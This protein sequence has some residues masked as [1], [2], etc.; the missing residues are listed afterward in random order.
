MVEPYTHT[1]TH[2]DIH[3]HGGGSAH[4]VCISSKLT[5]TSMDNNSFCASLCLCESAP[6]YKHAANAVGEVAMH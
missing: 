4:T 6:M 3:T 5:G 2:T 1:I